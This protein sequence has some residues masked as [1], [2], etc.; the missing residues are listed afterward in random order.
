MV[1]LSPL[2]SSKICFDAQGHPEKIIGSVRDISKRKIAEKALRESEEKFRSI[3]ENSA[4]A[5]FLTDQQGRYVYT[6]M[7]V[8]NMLGYTAEEMKS[9]IY[10]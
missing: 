4:D 3:M 6:N 7:A 10:R 8:T 5:I 9:K 2:C 1:H